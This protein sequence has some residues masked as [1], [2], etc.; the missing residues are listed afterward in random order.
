MV[1]SMGWQDLIYILKLPFFALKEGIYH[2]YYSLTQDLI[3]LA[4]GAYA[5]HLKLS[6]VLLS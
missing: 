1:V 2:F 5:V 6:I 3:V 4:R